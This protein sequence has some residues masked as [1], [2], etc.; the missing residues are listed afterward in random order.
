MSTNNFT[1]DTFQE[2]L[3]NNKKL[4]ENTAVSI[5]SRI[6]RMKEEYT[7]EYEYMKDGCAELL[8]DFTY[9]AEDA[10]N[11]IIPNVRIN[12]SGSY[13]KGL[14]S[15]KRALILYVE[16]LDTYTPSSPSVS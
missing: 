2:W 1:W 9:T 10:K 14:R 13:L 7:I 12:I 5:N 3:V 11:G 4:K 15:L 8:S 16:Y 6:N